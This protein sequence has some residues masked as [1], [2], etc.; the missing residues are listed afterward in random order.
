MS[1]TDEVFRESIYEVLY[2]HLFSFDSMEE[3]VSCLGGRASYLFTWND[4][5]LDQLNE[6]TAEQICV[7]LEC[8]L[9]LEGNPVKKTQTI[10]RKLDKALSRYIREVE[11]KFDTDNSSQLD[12]CFS[13]HLRFEEAEKQRIKSAAPIIARL[14][15]AYAA[16]REAEEKADEEFLDSLLVPVHEGAGGEV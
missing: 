15:V 11:V 10:E 3:S 9:E 13:C 12:Y 7:K 2:E 6:A 14:A 5:T 1:M 4:G 16:A 8:Y